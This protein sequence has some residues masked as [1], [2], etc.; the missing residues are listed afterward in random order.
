MSLVV[1]A[2]AMLGVS[3]VSMSGTKGKS[4]KRATAERQEEAKKYFVEGSRHFSR[5]EY[6]LAIDD[7]RS[8]F[9]IVR[10][11]DILFNIG[12]C[13]EE[14]GDTDNAIYHYEMYLR[15]YPTADDAENVRRRIAT[16][17]ELQAHRGGT[18]TEPHDQVADETTDPSGKSEKD[19]EGEP[20]S[21]PW[22]S[23]LRLGIGL[24][25]AGGVFGPSEGVVVPL[26]LMA[27]Y[28][29]L[30]WL[31]VSLS[32]NYGHYFNGNIRTTN[33]QYYTQNQVGM[34]AGVRGHWPVLDTLAI[35]AR[36]GV[37]LMWIDIG[38]SEGKT[39]LAGRGDG[40]MV[41]EFA[42]HWG[43]FGD[44]WVAVGPMFGG[45]VD[46]APF[47]TSV[48]ETEIGFALGVE[49]IF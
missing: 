36:L 23:G 41:W 12:R 29:V 49:Y 43:L 10:A 31:M 18:R 33:S 28:P 44:L 13:Y 27:H 32:F 26:E 42:D 35:M 37:S 40:G 25:A 45:D 8:A 24:G 21:G 6:R 4:Q 48:P 39:W 34:I 16:L 5:G 2:V 7:F 3:K 46:V 15:F 17:R 1:L 19:V 22:W 20:P 11:P 47:D 9:D 14:L 38:R 30:D